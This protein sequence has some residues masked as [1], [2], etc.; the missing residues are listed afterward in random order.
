MQEDRIVFDLESI[1]E[2][3]RMQLV[4]IVH[5]EAKKYFQQPGVQEKYEKWLEQREAK[6]ADTK[7]DE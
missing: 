4:T 1:P 3:E 7:K 6:K 2:S 5:E